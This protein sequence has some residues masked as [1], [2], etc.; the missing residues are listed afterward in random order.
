MK[1]LLLPIAMLLFGSIFLSNC[2][3][4][5][6]ERKEETEQTS[7][8]S[9][10]EHLID[11]PEIGGVEISGSDGLVMAD[12]DKDGHLDIVSVHESDTYYDSGKHGHIRIAFGSGDPDVWEN[13]TLAEG[14]EAAAAE[15]V[16]VADVNGDGYLD[17]IAA[18]ELAHLIY[19]QNPGKDIR[20]THW[21]RVIPAVTQNKGSYIRVFFADFNQD[22]KWEA[23]APNKGS[24]EG[25]AEESKPS[26]I[27]WFEIPDNPLDGDKWIEHEL[28]RVLVPIN[29]QPI[30]FDGD[31]DM[32]IMAGSR[33]EG[34]IFWYENTSKEEISFVEHAIQVEGSAKEPQDRLLPHTN[35][36]GFNMEYYDLNQDGRLDILLTEGR[37]EHLVYLEQPADPNQ[38]WKLHKIGDV[39][40]DLMVGFSLADINADGYPDIMAGSYS[41]GPRDED[42]E[43]DETY[44]LGRLAWFEHPGDIAKPWI[45]HEI[46]R[47]KRGMFDKFIP[48]D[49]DG[50]G[51]LDFV[52]TRGNSHPFDG[53]FWLEQIRSSTKPKSTFQAARKQDSEEM[54]VP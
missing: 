24:Q 44:P 41:M 15:D 29:S 1:K 38:T 32:D 48:Q 4:K 19:F 42:G 33:G 16:D 8:I 53:V 28:T 26:P 30:D 9:W 35:I 5:Q 51:D 49:M 22:G 12:L 7:Y 23:V 47:R 2:S 21:E 14:A 52:S 13:I 39:L 31:G 36:S 3:Q 11:D 50:D 27:S 34:K 10:K 43:V 46:S 45:R 54:K 40:P 37:F 17:I 25:N 20:K 18:V 6:S